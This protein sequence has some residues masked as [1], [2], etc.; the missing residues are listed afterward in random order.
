MESMM[1]ALGRALDPHVL[2]MRKD[3]D[4]A[5]VTSSGAQA[6][7]ARRRIMRTPGG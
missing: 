4:V 3:P 7:A 1:D 5:S 2:M 6:S